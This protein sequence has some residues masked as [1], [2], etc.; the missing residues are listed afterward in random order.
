MD[1]KPGIYRHYKGHEYRFIGIAKH[2]ETLEE[3]VVYQ[4]IVNTALIWARPK[5]MF[6]GDVEK[7][8]KIINRFTW[9]REG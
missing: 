7:D 2:S 1:I 8:G 4:D 9:V 5:E 3:L 6:F